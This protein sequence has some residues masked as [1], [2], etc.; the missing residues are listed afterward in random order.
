[1]RAR[2]ENP[3]SRRTG[4]EQGLKQ[5]S[6]RPPIN[7]ATNRES[8]ATHAALDEAS[9]VSKPARGR[10]SGR[11]DNLCRDSPGLPHDIVMLDEDRNILG[12]D[13]LGDT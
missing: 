13:S 2:N 8:W 9:M 1:M 4:N 5:F 12:A 6:I 7:Q 3:D 10:Y 11:P